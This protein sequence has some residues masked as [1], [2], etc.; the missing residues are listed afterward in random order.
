MKCIAVLLHN[1]TCKRLIFLHGTIENVCEERCSK[2]LLVPLLFG[3][4]ALYEFLTYPIESSICEMLYRMVIKKGK[5]GNNS[6]SGDRGAPHF[7]FGIGYI[8]KC[9]L[10][11]SHNSMYREGGKCPENKFSIDFE[12][13]KWNL[14]HMEAID[15]KVAR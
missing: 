3:R 14:T 1:H 8:G 5:N 9:L 12:G 7:Y 6:K 15:W 11:L 2:F 13:K 4:I 10:R